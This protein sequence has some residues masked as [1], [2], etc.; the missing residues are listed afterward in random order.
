MLSL[1]LIVALI[2]GTA[3]MAVY[4]L[5]CVAIPGLYL[6]CRGIKPAL[7]FQTIPASAAMLT[8]RTSL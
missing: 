6:A 4:M 7:Y 1:T 2:T 5:A 3:P 8:G